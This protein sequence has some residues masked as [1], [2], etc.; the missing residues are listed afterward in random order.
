MLPSDPEP[1]DGGPAL[2]THHARAMRLAEEASASGKGCRRDVRCQVPG[3]NASI[4]KAYHSRH[5]ICQLHAKASCVDV[6]GN[7]KRFCQQCSKLHPIEEFDGKLKSCKKTLQKHNERR[8]QGS[9]K[10]NGTVALNQKEVPN[11]LGRTMGTFGIKKNGTG[12]GKRNLVSPMC[13]SASALKESLLDLKPKVRSAAPNEQQ[14]SD[15]EPDR[16]GSHIQEHPVHMRTKYAMDGWGLQTSTSFVQL[17]SLLEGQPSAL[18]VEAQQLSLG[19]AN[20]FLPSFGSYDFSKLDFIRQTT[21]S[22]SRPLENHINEP[23]SNNPGPF[24]HLMMPTFSGDMGT[25]SLHQNQYNHGLLPNL[26]SGFSNL[27]FSQLHP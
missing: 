3:C 26:S 7:K 5:R 14:T 9:A 8:K 16:S 21:S 24:S 20:S 25:L 12:I 13:T 15:Q 19:T 22:P 23:S 27:D 11:Q 1:R 10:T 4:T 17:E 2:K 18:P 6:H